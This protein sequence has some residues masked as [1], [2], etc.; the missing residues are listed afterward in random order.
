MN[1]LPEGEAVFVEPVVGPPFEVIFDGVEL[2][3][4][5][6]FHFAVEWERIG[7]RFI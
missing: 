2:D 3:G 1:Y 6:L 7:G 5:D 4:A